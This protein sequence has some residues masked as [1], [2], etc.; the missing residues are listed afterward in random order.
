MIPLMHKLAKTFNMVYFSPPSIFLGHRKVTYR[1][2][3]SL[4]SP[5][6]YLIYQMIL[7][8][9]QPDLVIEIGTNKGGGALYLAD[10]LDLN[11]RGIVHTIDM[12]NTCAPMVAAHPRIR[13]FTGGWQ[14]YDP[15]N[16]ASFERVI[17]I[18]DGS[19]HYSD[20]LGA[21]RR[22]APL[23]TPDSYMIVEDG[24]IARLGL[25]R[26][27]QGGP[28]RAIH[29]FLAEDNRFIIDRHWCDFFGVNATFNVNGYLKRVR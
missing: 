10:L 29:E 12:E 24:I 15:Q 14:A 20:V 9:L 21:L 6:D 17:V 5:F 23:V 27:Y 7:T 1:G 4:R 8:G 26:Q 16:A 22:F 25:S 11:N 3:K 19:H 28:L 13:I 2:I 18:D